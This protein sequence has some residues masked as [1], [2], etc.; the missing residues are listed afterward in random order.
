MLRYEDNQIRTWDHEFDHLSKVLHSLGKEGRVIFEYGIPSQNFVIDVVLLM[1]GKIFVIEYKDGA[2]ATS[3]SQDALKQCR[4]YALRLKYFHST[5]NNKWIIPILVAMNAP[6]SAFE[7]GKSEDIQVW[8]TIKCNRYNLEDTLL[9][10]CDCCK[11]TCDNSWEA[12]L[13]KGIYKT[14]PTIIK[15][16]CDMWERNNVKGL[17]SGE[18]DKDTRLAAEDFVMKIVE[19]SKE[20]K[21]KS[22][23]FVTGVPGA[24]KTL[25]GL[26][27]S[28]RCQEYGSSM[29][30]GNEPLVRVLST[31][32]R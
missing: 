17:D 26:G 29:L 6:K 32:L 24:G 7:Q 18:S 2:S 13:E 8:N 27:L 5:S 4:N 31:A 9:T 25:V 14:T 3:Y 21:K 28:V 16:A 12:D 11:T 20:K 30:S 10:I 23:V 15:A 1:E 22:I 19:Q